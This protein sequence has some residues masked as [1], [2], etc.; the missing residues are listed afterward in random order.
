MLKK[1]FFKT[2]EECEV[3]FELAAD[4]AKHA[5]LVCEVNGWQPIQMKRARKGPFR[6]KLRFPKEASFEFRY[7]VDDSN[8][9]NDEAA[10][11]YRANGLGGRNG[12]LETTVPV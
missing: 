10:D 11:A 4:D 3:T 7:L 8:W 6:A 5:E 12:V 1:R 2:K 9:I